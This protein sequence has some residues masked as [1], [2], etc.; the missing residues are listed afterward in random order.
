MTLLTPTAEFIARIESTLNLDSKPKLIS[1]SQN[2]VFEAYLNNIKI[3]LRLTSDKH[4]THEQIQSEITL[5]NGIRNIVE[6]PHQ[7][8]P[9]KPGQYVLPITFE[10]DTYYAVAFN[11]IDG[12]PL[13]P[14]HT[15]EIKSAARQLFLLSFI[16]RQRGK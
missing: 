3:A 15:Y 9:L 1:H 10:H 6:L 13:D 4:R 14:R 11:Y 16:E 5:I 8:V 12:S 7:P 2:T